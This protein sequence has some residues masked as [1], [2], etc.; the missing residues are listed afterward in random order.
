MKN[1]FQELSGKLPKSADNTRRNTVKFQ[2]T[3]GRDVQVIMTK[4]NSR[5]NQKNLSQ[6]E[7]YIS[8][9]WLMSSLLGTAIRAQWRKLCLES[10]REPPIVVLSAL[11]DVTLMKLMAMTTD[12]SHRCN[13]VK[14]NTYADENCSAA[15]G[16]IHNDTHIQK[17]KRRHYSTRG[18][19]PDAKSDPWR[20]SNLSHA[21][22]YRRLLIK[23][24]LFSGP[25]GILSNVSK[26]RMLF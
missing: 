16:E 1:F 10:G 22:R 13:V 2:E 19:D 23:A 6:G 8:S 12:G 3:D 11:K 9:K 18:S 14:W 4:R 5:P 15:D 7:Y 21:H 25:V 20:F 24:E 26:K 17:K